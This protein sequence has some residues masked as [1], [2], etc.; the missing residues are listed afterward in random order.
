ML[1]NRRDALRAAGLLAGGALIA[2][3]GVLAACRMEPHTRLAGRILSAEDQNLIE[4]IADTLLP[5]TASS[6]GARAAGGGPTINLILTDCYDR[7]TQERVVSGLQSFRNACQARRSKA[8]T[9]LTRAEREAFLR[10]IDKESKAAEAAAAAAAPSVANETKIPSGSP[11]D[12]DSL[13]VAREPHYFGLI[14]ELALGAY[15]SSEIG[16]TRAR[17]YV[18][19][20][21]HYTGCMPLAPGQPAWG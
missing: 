6:P 17:R 7:S 12:R 14:R 20:P 4:E 11:A 15:F 21:G 13:R 8:F 9:E 2:S 5:T 16:M 19:V 18:R 10:E 3:T 1:M